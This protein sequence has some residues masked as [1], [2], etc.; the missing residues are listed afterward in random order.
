MVKKVWEYVCSFRHNTRTWRTDTGRRYMYATDGRKSALNAPGTDTY[1][2]VSVSYGFFS[3]SKHASV[4]VCCAVIRCSWV[5]RGGSTPAQ[6]L[7]SLPPVRVC[8]LSCA[9][10][11]MIVL[12]YLSVTGAPVLQNVIILGFVFVRTVPHVWTPAVIRREQLPAGWPEIQVALLS[13]RTTRCFVSVQSLASTVQNVEQ[14]FVVS[15]VGYRFTTAF[16]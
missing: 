9:L 7:L 13:Q 2:G 1:I 4:K 8:L 5:W 16:S 3:I 12:S 6:V 11:V 10:P 15:Y 14:S